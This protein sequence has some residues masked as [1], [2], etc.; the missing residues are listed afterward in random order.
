MAN[1]SAIVTLP[2]RRS[3][4]QIDLELPNG[5]TA[6]ATIARIHQWLNTHN[7]PVP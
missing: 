2:E 5:H 1:R 7:G 6:D 4:Y 3:R